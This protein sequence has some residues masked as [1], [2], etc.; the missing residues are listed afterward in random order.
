MKLLKILIPLL[1]LLL[2]SKTYASYYDEYKDY[3]KVIR[4]NT[5]SLKLSYYE[6]W[7][8]IWIFDISSWDEEHPTPLWKFRISTKSKS[9][10]S[11]SAWKLMPYR[12]EFL[13]W[14]YW[15]HALPENFKWE[16]DTKSEIWSEAAWWCIRLE[17]NDAKKLYDW[18]TKWTYVLISYDKYEFASKEDDK[19]IKKYLDFINNWK[20]REAYNL[21]SDKKLAFSDYKKI[22]KWLKVKL[23]S[24]NK[25]KDWDFIVKT[26][27]YKNESLIKKST[28]VFQISN[29]KIMKSY[30][31]KK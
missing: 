13:D 12:M 27:I 8:I 31:I 30:N 25:N 7:K 5:F 1:I 26:E 22:Y 29:W 4:V 15:I 20:Y 16:L 24:I 18:T 21:K 14:V 10:L 9:M 11:K 6:K 3:E 17:K 2:W 19:V 28:S 23:L